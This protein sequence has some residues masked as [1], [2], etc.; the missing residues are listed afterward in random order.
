MSTQLTF[1]S[2]VYL[3]KFSISFVCRRL[4]FSNILTVSP[5][6]ASFQTLVVAP[7]DT[8][9]GPLLDL[10]VKT[11]PRSQICFKDIKLPPG[12][13]SPDLRLTHTN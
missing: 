9:C 10:G 12:G 11:W 6:L 5:R 3:I 2:K 7:W 1:N 8:T 4:F 13:V